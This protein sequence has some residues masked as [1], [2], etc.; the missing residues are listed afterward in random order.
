MRAPGP[1]RGSGSRSTM[2]FARFT[3]VV[4]LVVVGGPLAGCRRRRPFTE[5]IPGPSGATLSPT[6]LLGG[7]G[8]VEGFDRALAPVPLELPR[9]HGA[10]P[11]F[12]NEWWYFTGVLESEAGAS[13]RRR[14]GYQLTIFRQALDPHPARRG[15]AWATGNIYMGHLAIADIDGDP[16]RP[17]FHAYQRFAR[18]GLGLAGARAVPFEVWVDDWQAA[19]PATGEASFPMTLRARAAVGDQ[20]MAAAAAGSAPADSLELVVG[21]GRG[22]ILQGDRGLSQKGSRPGDASYYHSFTRL[23]TRGTLTLGGQPF[24]VSGA[25]WLDR[26]WST[27]ALDAA[28]IGWDWLGAQLDDGRDVMVYRLRITGGADAAQSRATLIDADG[29][30]HLFG[31][32]SFTFSPVGQWQSAD[33]RARYPAAMRLRIPAAAVD[34]AITPMLADQELALAIRYWEGAVAVAGVGGGHAVS[35]SGYLELTGYAAPPGR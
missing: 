6:A 24:A 17:R 19:G 15:S 16:R 5:E 29:R 21:A 34:L 7:G 35:G 4:M 13:P 14:F 8:D 32:E 11:R 2:A 20:P 23:P 28:V 25:S 26:E 22:P 31:P 33:G 10:H 1:G 18:D 9:D 12:R 3:V 27:G 30:T